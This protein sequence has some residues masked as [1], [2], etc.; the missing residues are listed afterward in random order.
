M[1]HFFFVVVVVVVVVRT[2][3]TDPYPLFTG[4]AHFAAGISCGLANLAAGLAI[5]IV[6][7]FGTRAAAKQP[8]IYVGMVLMLIFGE[9]LG[10]YGLIVAIILQAKSGQCP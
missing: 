1:L 8:K 9:A 6:G 5:G 7:D 10:L 3:S 4:Y 2:V